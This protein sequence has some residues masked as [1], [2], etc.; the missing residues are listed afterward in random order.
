V[1]CWTFHWDDDGHFI[2]SPTEL[3]GAG[4]RWVFDDPGGSNA[5]KVKSTA[6][7][8]KPFELL[9]AVANAY[10]ESA[11]L[12]EIE[13]RFK[14]ASVVK[15]RTPGERFPRMWRGRH[16]V[17]PLSERNSFISAVNSANA[18]FDRFR[19][20]TRTIEPNTLNQSAFG[21]ELRQLLIL[22]ATEVERAWKGVLI[23]NS[24]PPPN[25]DRYNTTH[26]VRLL[27]PLRLKE[28]ELKLL[29]FPAY[30]AIAPFEKWDEKKPTGSLR[31]YDDY[32]AVKHAGETELH[33]ATL[34]NVI[35]ALAGLVVLLAAQAGPDFLMEEP[36]AVKDFRATKLPPWDSL[37]EA[38]T[39][40]F[41]NPPSLVPY[42][43]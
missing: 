18:L 15:A 4:Q 40:S 19:H 2:Y 42:P 32:N 34:A 35:G 30:P 43:F 37:D 26:Y 8:S 20:V 3:V 27:E 10:D 36:W 16:S 12:A 6:T 5:V 24:F 28:F 9:P 1:R 31:W 39:P 41:G 17:C 33:K 22:T 7:L 23:A 29:M 13:A 14:G 21:Q 25:N 11:I 38:Y